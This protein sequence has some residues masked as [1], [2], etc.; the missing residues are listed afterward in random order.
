MEA[1]VQALADHGQQLVQPLPGFGGD[2]DDVLPVGADLSH[3]HIGFVEHVDAGGGLG[4]QLVDEAL[5]HRH[6][7]PPLGVG[8]VDDVKDKVS[9]A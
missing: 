4:A 5:H 3:I 1:R 8:G 6:L 9:V 2:G 7:V